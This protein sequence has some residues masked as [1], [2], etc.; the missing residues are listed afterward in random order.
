MKLS[1]EGVTFYSHLP[2]SGFGDA[3]CQYVTALVE[4]GVR[5]A[6]RP[7]ANDLADGKLPE[8]ALG[9]APREPRAI[10]ERALGE[11]IGEISLV[12]RSL[13]DLPFAQAALSG[14]RNYAYIAWE[15]NEIDPSWVAPLNRFD[16]LLVPCEFNRRALLAGGV[17][18]PVTVVPHIARPLQGAAT[19]ID[20]P[21][22]DHDYLFYTIGSWTRRKGMEETIR[23][24]LAAFSADDPVLLVVLTNEIDTMAARAAPRAPGYTQT[25]AW[26]LAR[27]LAD[28]PG[29][30]RVHLV[31]G[32]QEPTW[33]DALHERADCFI[34]LTHSEGWGL[35]AFDALLHGN[36]AIITGYGGQCD[37]LGENYPLAV[38]YHM[39]LVSDVP[40]DGSYKPFASSLWA[41]ADQDHAVNLL[42]QVYAGREKARTMA[43]AQGDQLRSAYSRRRIG[44]DLATALGLSE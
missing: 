40:P 25:V 34:S 12:S 9:P 19:S 27:I 4:L 13:D 39:S 44:K 8:K 32:L 29:A 14:E 28:Y 22:R 2:G 7:Y 41:H 43:S 24:Y 30:A 33:V 26:T 38:N 18:A 21:A 3:A 35:G 5:V 6:W 36:P 20:L 11:A 1:G 37:Y 15:L 16:G 10:L 17:S 23:A 31:A 42:R